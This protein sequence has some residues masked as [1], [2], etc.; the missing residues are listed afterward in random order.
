M[1][2]GGGGAVPSLTILDP[3]L[4]R[5]VGG[6]L[7]VGGSDGLYCSTSHDPG[8]APKKFWWFGGG[9]GRGVMGQCG[10]AVNKR[11]DGCVRRV[12]I[13]WLTRPLRL[14]AST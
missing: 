11:R 2:G 13:T 14:H 1:D 3:N 10:S 7:V 9:W 6:E 8:S 4:L 12:L 5:V